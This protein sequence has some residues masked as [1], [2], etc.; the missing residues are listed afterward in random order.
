MLHEILEAI[1]CRAEEIEWLGKAYTIREV[2]AGA[3]F[4][5]VSDLSG[6]EMMWRIF[7]RSIFYKDTGLQVFQDDDIVELKRSA[8]LRLAPLW[9]V[10]NRVNGLDGGDNAKN[11]QAVQG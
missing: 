4:G 7:V 10:V 5:D 9:M 2:E 3:N 11:S 6:A 1:K 8:R